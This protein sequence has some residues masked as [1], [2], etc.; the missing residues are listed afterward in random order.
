M[1][2]LNLLW[3]M[4]M[5]TGCICVFVWLLINSIAAVV[6]FACLY[7]FGTGNFTALLPSV[8][9]QITPDENLGARVGAFY[10]IVAIASLVGTPIGSALI[11]DDDKREGYWWLIVFSVCLN[12][13]SDDSLT[14]HR[15]LRS[16]SA[17]CSCL[18]VACYMIRIYGRSGEHLKGVR[19]NSPTTIS[20]YRRISCGTQECT[21]VYLME[22][23]AYIRR[24]V[25]AV[26]Y[27]SSIYRV[28]T[29]RIS[30]WQFIV[31]RSHYPSQL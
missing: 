16:P 8:V 13:E 17:P 11:T 5:F 3:P 24:Q 31:H 19:A 12:K 2:R 22:I 7:G 28:R 6:L 23:F 26:T 21:G 14:Y 30:W 25:H 15:V 1:G 18:E 20:S 29:R 27:H 4:V 9:G 10:S